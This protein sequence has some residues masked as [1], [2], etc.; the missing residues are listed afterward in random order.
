MRNLDGIFGKD[1]NRL[2]GLADEVRAL[3]GQLDA[4]LPAEWRGNIK[5]VRLH[6]DTLVLL[7]R[8]PALAA[9]LRQM[10][11]GLTAALRQNGLQVTAI[12]MRMQAETLP[13]EVEKNKKNHELSPAALSAFR[14]A[15]EQ[16]HDGPVRDAV[17]HLLQRRQR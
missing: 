14:A 10:E 12:R 3:Q 13:H 5:V 6:G 11:G 8:L 4:V 1:L 2:K 15:A 17:Q 9:K 16:L 7:T